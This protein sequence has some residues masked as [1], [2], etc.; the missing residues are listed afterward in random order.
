MAMKRARVW[1]LA[2]AGALAIGLGI[3]WAVLAAPKA[4][5]TPSAPSQALL[6]AAQGLDGVRID[7][8]FDPVRRTLTVSQTMTLVNRTG[9]AQRLLILRAWTNAFQSEDHSPAATDELY[10][11]CYPAGFSAG[12]VTVKTLTAAL[13]GGD[14]QAVPYVVGDAAQT[15]LRVSLPAD[16]PA[17]GTLTLTASYEVLIPQ[18]AYRFGEHGGI[19]ALGNVF[20][21]PA[22]YVDGAYR[23]DD[24]YPIGDPFLNE[25]RNYDVTLT[26]PEGYDAGGSAAATVASVTDGT[27]TLHMS[28]P[29]ARDFALCVSRDYQLVQ[30]ME[31][32]VLVNAYAKTGDGALAM[33][34]T[35]RKALSVYGGL[36]GAYPYPAFTL[37]EVDFPFDGMAYPGMSMVAGDVLAKGGTDLEQLVAREVAHQWWYAVVGSDPWYDAWQDEAICE[38][39]LLSYW[40]A[41]Y[42]QAAREELRYARAETAMRVTIPQGVTPGSPLDYFGDISEYRVVVYGRGAAAL[43]ALDTAMG[44]KLDAFLRHYRDTFAFR[45]ATRADFE[46][47]LRAYT[48]EDWS[49]LLSDYL[50]TYLTN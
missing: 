40:G 12:G 5:L 1:L 25:C 36:Y 17:G 47:L 45:I 23:T 20:L 34:D 8:S 2:A 38:Y 21:T 11:S 24:Y 13:A 3:L 6:A 7:A 18:A 48:G 46:A 33:L 4:V 19:W 22:P 35:A 27:A 50:D 10:D 44:G 30:G 29:A 9:T 42:G 31:G 14:A 49:P 37:C 16:W 39:S 41:R 32:G 15:V 26:L 28:A 43:W